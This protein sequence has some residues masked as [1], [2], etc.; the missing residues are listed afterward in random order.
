M[1]LLLDFGYLIGLVAGSPWLLY[2]IAKSGAWRGLASR[3]GF[4]LGAP[5]VGAIWLHGS[6]AGEVSLLKPLVAKLELDRPN[7]PLI[8]STYTATG[9]SAATKAYPRHRVVLFPFD[10]SFVVE[11]FFRHFDPRLVVIVES[12]YWPNFLLTAQRRGVPVVVLNGKMSAKSHAAYRRFAPIPRVMQSLRLIAVQSA[13]HAER[14]AS[15]GVPA[16]RLRVTGNMKYDLA[17]PS[18]NGEDRRVLRQ[19]LGYGDDDVVVIG[20]SLHP[21]EPEALLDA[22]AALGESPKAALILVPRYPADAYAVEQAAA[23]RGYDS[24]RKTALDGGAARAPGRGGVLIVD[25]VGELGRL[26]G[27]AD[28]AF[29]GG[30]LNFRGSNKGGHNLMEPAIRGV[31][32]LFGPYNFSFKDTVE[33]LLRQDAGL[34]VEDGDALAAAISSLAADPVERRRLGERGRQ[35]VLKG[36]GATKRNYDLLLRVLGNDS[37][38]LQAPAFERTMPR[39]SGDLDSR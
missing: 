35:V 5:S 7:V 9:L 39:A 16:D 2:R 17:S 37:G 21:G 3:F 36:Q 34:L 14:L 13:E 11:R 6:S 31:P 1:R 29:V 8:V 20:G 27:A 19:E 26:Y 12:E 4:R 10:F 22:Y 38:R 25:T 30:S 24:V 18:P 32:V 33:D 15:L 28:V 23:A